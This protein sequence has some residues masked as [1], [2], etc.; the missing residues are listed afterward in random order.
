M[1]VCVCVCV[2]S[3]G[4]GKSI[5]VL[6]GEG[7]TILFLLRSHE[8]T[9]FGP[10][11]KIIMQNVE[12]SYRQNVFCLF[13]VQIEPIKLVNIATCTEVLTLI[14]NYASTLSLIVPSFS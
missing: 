1:C 2:C 14:S 4:S 5:G 7:N 12:E 3:G 10:R 13:E 8:C 9:L 11:V 6:G